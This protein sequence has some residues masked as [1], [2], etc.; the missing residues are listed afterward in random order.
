M[1]HHPHICSEHTADSISSL[2]LFLPPFSLVF[3]CSFAIW[4][5]EASPPAPGS[6]AQSNSPPIATRVIGQS[7]V[8]P[9]SHS[10]PMN[11]FRAPLVLKGEAKKEGG[12][13]S[14]RGEAAQKAEAKE[15]HETST[16]YVSVP[17]PSQEKTALLAS[18]NSKKESNTTLSTNNHATVT[19]AN[20]L[21]PP[22]SP[23][24]IA[25]TAPSSA[26]NAQTEMATLFVRDLQFAQT[27]E[28]LRAGA[29]RVQGTR[30]LLVIS[31]PTSLQAVSEY[32]S[33][34]GLCP[35][36]FR[37]AESALLSLRAGQ[38]DDIEL[39]LFDYAIPATNG[40]EL[41]SRVREMP[42]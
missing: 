17:S 24:F 35:V 40:V 4:S 38:L 14:Q 29:A 2:H 34:N 42:R 18:S 10:A 19:V 13:T 8:I 33:D 36:G 31:Q 16:V 32:M 39:G 30:V 3:S 28:E 21:A 25:V 7:A 9:R 23:S 6:A 11:D 15:E 20:T 27:N 5:E 12:E 41:A 22:V 1:L 26:A 37:A